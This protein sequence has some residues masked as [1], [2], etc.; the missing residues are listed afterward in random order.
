MD[1]STGCPTDVNNRLG[2][3]L[4]CSVSIVHSVGL[5]ILKLMFSLVI[6]EPSR[7][8][9]P[10][11][12]DATAVDKEAPPTSTSSSTVAPPALP[13]NAGSLKPTAP[14]AMPEPG[15]EGPGAEPTKST[16]EPEKQATEEVSSARM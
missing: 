10:N 1:T 12:A 16:A 8:V 14:S 5:F 4:V 9:I 6:S 7:A 13:V 15:P 11:L 3:P 2:D